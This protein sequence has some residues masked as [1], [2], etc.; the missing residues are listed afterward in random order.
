MSGFLLLNGGVKLQG[1]CIVLL[2]K[3][4]IAVQNLG[5]EMP[6]DGW[7]GRVPQ[8]TVPSAPQMRRGSSQRVSLEVNVMLLASKNIPGSVAFRELSNDALD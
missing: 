6:D 7:S 2:R 8:A 4:L 3:F 5:A 1:G